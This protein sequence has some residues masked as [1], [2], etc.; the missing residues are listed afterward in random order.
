MDDSHSTLNAINIHSSLCKLPTQHLGI[1]QLS[2]PSPTHQTILSQPG[3]PLEKMSEKESFSY[4]YK[5][6]IFGEFVGSSQ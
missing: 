4:A 3:Q 1:S 6:N 2:L 5:W